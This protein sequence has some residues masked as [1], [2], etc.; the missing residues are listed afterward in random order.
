[1]VPTAIRQP[2]SHRALAAKDQLVRKRYQKLGDLTKIISP[3]TNKVTNLTNWWT[4]LT[5][6]VHIMVVREETEEADLVMSIQIVC[7]LIFLL[8]IFTSFSFYIFI[9]FPKNP[10]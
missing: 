3:A 9:L 2:E 5:L 10:F 4:G 7:L 1:M 8:V 6:S